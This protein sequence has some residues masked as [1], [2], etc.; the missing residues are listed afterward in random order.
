MT[1]VFVIVSAETTGG[2]TGLVVP[3]HPGTVWLFCMWPE[4]ACRAPFTVTVRRDIPKDLAF[5]GVS[6][7]CGVV[8]AVFADWHGFPLVCFLYRFYVA[9]YPVIVG[10]GLKIFGINGDIMMEIWSLHYK[11]LLTNRIDHYSAFRLYTG[12]PELSVKKTLVIHGL[13]FVDK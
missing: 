10:R 11:K 7:F 4:Q 3:S 12:P 8:H 5:S 13:K 6:S 2:D 9:G 1:T